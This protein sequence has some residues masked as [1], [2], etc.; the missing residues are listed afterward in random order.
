[1]PRI[2]YAMPVFAGVL[3]L[4]LLAGC[5]DLRENVEEI[6]EDEDND[7]PRTVA[8]ECDGG[9]EF[10]ARFSGD[11]DRAVVDAGNETYELEYTGQNDGMRIYR[12]DDDEVRLVVSND[13]AHLRIADAV[14]FRGL[15]AVVTGGAAPKRPASS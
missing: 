13:E 1:M 7:G 15:R 2:L 4:S 14:Q 12:D 3:G 8:F 5:A 10:R 11:R 6:V 9:R